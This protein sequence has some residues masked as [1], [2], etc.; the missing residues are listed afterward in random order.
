[1]P[2]TYDHKNVKSSLIIVTKLEEIES[3][4]EVSKKSIAVLDQRQKCVF[5]IRFHK[6]LELLLTSFEVVSYEQPT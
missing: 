6:F 3:C 4:I 5:C 2:L 1:M